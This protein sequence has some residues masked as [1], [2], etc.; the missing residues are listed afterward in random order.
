MVTFD[1]ALSIGPTCTAAVQL[2]R[3]FKRYAL[4]GVF[5]WQVTP[6][7]TFVQYLEQ[8]FTGFMKLSDLAVEDGVVVNQRF[9]TGHPHEID[10]ALPIELQFPKARSRHDFLCS[11]TRDALKGRFGR[12]LL[13]LSE[14]RPLDEVQTVEEA[15]RAYCPTLRFTVA[16]GPPRTDGAAWEGDPAVWDGVFAG[17]R[18]ATATR[19]RKRVSMWLKLPAYR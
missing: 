1:C 11:R 4:H 19:V 18:V 6:A 8:D 3:K 9:R 7:E 13:Q 14:T 5:D 12:V 16:N 17:D 2:R 10:P 15:V